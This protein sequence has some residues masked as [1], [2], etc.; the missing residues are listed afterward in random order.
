[1]FLCSQC[2][3]IVAISLEPII[4]S[5]PSTD[6]MIAQQVNV[7][8]REYV[9]EHIDGATKNLMASTLGIGLQEPEVVMESV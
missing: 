1:M 6:V 2:A 5:S 4:C 7:T 9:I 8:N 3:H